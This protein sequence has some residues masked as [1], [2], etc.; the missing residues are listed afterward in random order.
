MREA[1]ASF[2]FVPSE[3]CSSLAQSIP[4]SSSFE[5]VYQDGGA[6]VAVLNNTRP[7]RAGSP[8]PDRR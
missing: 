1:G 6:I 5:V 7:G 3:C 8:L 4:L 2:A